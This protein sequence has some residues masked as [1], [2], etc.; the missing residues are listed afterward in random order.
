MLCNRSTSRGEAV[1]AVG[2][3]SGGLD[4]TVAIQLMLDQGIEVSAFN[5]VTT[6]CCCTPRAS[7]CSSAAAAVKKL[8]VDLKVVNVTEEFLPI[9][10]NPKHGHGSGMN[11]CLDCRILMFRKAREYMEEIGASFIVTGDVLGQ[12]PMSQRRDAMRLIDRESGLTGYVVRPLSAALLEP[13][14][15]E[16]EG[17][18]DREKLLAVSGRSR[19][20]Q[21][22]LAKE[23]G[24]KDYPCP[25]GGCLLTDPTFAQ[26]L[27]DL[28]RHV[29]ELR[30]EDAALLKMG[31]H[32]RLSPAAKAVVGRD[33]KENHQLGNQLR[34]G[35]YALEISGQPGPLTLVRGDVADDELAVAAAITS[36]YGKSGGRTPTTV[37]CRRVGD[38]AAVSMS[39]DPVDRDSIKPLM[40]GVEGA[41]KESGPP[42][43]RSGPSVRTSDAHIT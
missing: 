39:V 32:F 26:R 3:L 30:S 6:F 14:V 18:V 36:R 43:S 12:R 41:D 15:P 21:M 40:I 9:V 37:L 17:W 22:E 13:T 19:R 7:S 28:L 4:S 5:I 16:R 10:A 11:P 38:G 33:Q 2:L 25:A 34:D 35:D 27:R 31:R 42:R 23:M 20:P 8:D 24:L 1:K 29:G